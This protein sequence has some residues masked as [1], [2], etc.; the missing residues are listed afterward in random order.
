M[1]DNS[2]FIGFTPEKSMRELIIKLLLIII[3]YKTIISCRTIATCY[4][5]YI[6]NY[7]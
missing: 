2:K 6:V 7:N 5:E 3:N 4:R 1:Q